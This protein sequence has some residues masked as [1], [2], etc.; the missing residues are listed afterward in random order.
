MDGKH[1]DVTMGL[2]GAGGGARVEEDEEVGGG[3]GLGG[4][5][6]VVVVVSCLGAAERCLEARSCEVLLSV[7]CVLLECS[8]RSVD[9]LEGA[10]HGR[11]RG[12]RVPYVGSRRPTTSKL[13]FPRPGGKEQVR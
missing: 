8:C 7:A 12:Q 10:D 3:C 6:V 1:L 4:V 13:P 11:V 9:I 2:A 5:V